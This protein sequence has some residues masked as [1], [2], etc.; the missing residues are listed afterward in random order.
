MA[1][2]HSS[3]E[4]AKVVGRL[5]AEESFNDAAELLAEWARDYAGCEEA[6]V[7]M[8]AEGGETGPWVP[9]CAHQGA[10]SGFQ[11]DE[12]LVAAN[13]CL[14]GRVML[15]DVD[16]EQPFFTA[17]GSFVWGRVSSMGQRFSPEQI[18]P[19]RN[20]C[21]SAG[22]ESVAIFAILDRGKPVGCLHLADHAPDV[23]QDAVELVEEVCAQ[24]GGIL[25]KHQSAERHKAL[26]DAI[27]TALLPKNPPQTPGLDIGVSFASAGDTGYMGGDFYDVIEIPHH[28]V[29]LLVGDYS[30]MGI[31]ASGLAARARYTLASLAVN[32]TGPAHL[33]TTA[34]EILVQSLP[35]DRFVSVVA[36]LISLEKPIARVSL[37]GHPPPVFLFPD[38][39]CAEMPAEA[40]T[41]LGAFPETVYQDVSV[42]LPEGVY[43][44]L[45]TDGISEAR[46]GQELF[47]VNGIGR[48]WQALK[49]RNA[50][51]VARAISEAADA[52]QTRGTVAPDD[53]LVLAA[54]LSPTTTTARGRALEQDA[55]MAVR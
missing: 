52:F 3:V 39:R 42:A 41:P 51:E 44:V 12:S 10:D 46:R 25:L 50:D 48:T 24:A 54:R 40:N 33:L 16:V 36:C 30:G 6:S 26:T 18:G 17:G 2:M 49:P 8:M 32:A 31:E 38:G 21:V 1:A 9:A 37:A 35:S 15:R 23:F 45:F 29:L 22:F 7:R 19:L 55:T 34:N 5:A 20:R 28:G 43:L 11:R 27:R 53:R 4:L 13:E 47:G 14:C